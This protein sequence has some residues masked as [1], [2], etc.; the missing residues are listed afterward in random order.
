MIL[1]ALRA[2]YLVP[3]YAVAGNLENYSEWEKLIRELKKTYKRDYD[4][5]HSLGLDIEINISMNPFYMGGGTRP[6]GI[7]FES[8]FDHDDEEE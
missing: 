3:A 2:F 5:T 4:E 1:R 7:D 8:T 6:G